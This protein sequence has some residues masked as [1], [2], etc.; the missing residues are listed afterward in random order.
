VV[1]V[2]PGHGERTRILFVPDEVMAAALGSGF[3]Q[4]RSVAFRSAHSTAHALAIVSSWRPQ[5]VVF[6]NQLEATAATHFCRAFAADAKSH[7]SKLLMITEALQDADFSELASAGAD[8]HLVS[9]VDPPQLLATIA[10]LL[11][12]DRS[13]APRVR[14][15]ALLHTEGF[16]G[17]SA[18]VDAALGA[19][20]YVSED[21]LVI[22]SHRHLALDARG[23]LHFFLPGAPERLSV[24]ARVRASID[25][26]RLRYVLELADLA[27]Q[28]RAAIRRYVESQRVPAWASAG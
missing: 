14:V 16:D 22:E 10:E 5:L 12:L 17:E 2:P 9:P 13:A 20:L 28:H 19:A 18:S 27:P 4:R 3:L 25:E 15:D 24:N 26:I 7:G 6:R 21:T 11:A 23:R 8:A 1:S